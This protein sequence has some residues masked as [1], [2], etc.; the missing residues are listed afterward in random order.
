MIITYE[1]INIQPVIPR[2]SSRPPNYRIYRGG[3][4]TTPLRNKKYELQYYTVLG[5]GQ[6]DTIA[7]MMM[8]R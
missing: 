3:P 8:L 6:V 2:T 4:F 5:T 1:Y 7:R